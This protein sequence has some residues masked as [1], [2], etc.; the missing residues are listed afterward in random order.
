MLETI[1]KRQ[2]HTFMN[3]QKV[4]LPLIAPPFLH[5]GPALLCPL[6]IIISPVL[7]GV[8]SVVTAKD[9]P[10]SNVA[11]LANDELVFAE[12]KVTAIGQLIAIVV[13]DNKLLAKQAVKLV[14]V[15]YKD[16]PAI[17][18]IE[19]TTKISTCSYEII[20]YSICIN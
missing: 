14:K 6:C 9:V 4:S 13:A 8:R 19:V 10:G 7:Q 16:I 12:D 5:P 17:L 15:T 1:A 2:N 11:G 18:T 20:H 3:W